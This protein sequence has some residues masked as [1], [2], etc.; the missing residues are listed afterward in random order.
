[1]TRRRPTAVLALAV[2]LVLAGCTVGYQPTADASGP[3][4]D[5][6]PLGYY[7]GY[8]HNDTLDIE[9]EDG[10]SARETEAV[11][12]RSM[13]RIQRLRGLR[14]RE[15]VDVEIVTRETFHE[16][17][18]DVWGEPTADQRRLDN[19]QHEA[20]FLVGPDEDVFDVRQRNR[21]GVVLGFYQPSEKRLVIVSGNDPATLDDE[22][23][24]AHELMH[25]LQDQHFGLSSF[26]DSTL[27]SVNARNG[28][29][30]GDATVV[31]QAY[32]R[33]CETGKWECVEARTAS[34]G[35]PVGFHWG[36]YFLGY[37]PYAEGPNFVEHHRDRGGWTTID[38][39][40]SDVPTT[41]AEIID[42]ETYRRDAYG[43][44]VVEDRNDRSWERITVR[45]GA[46][47]AT[48]GEAGLTSMFVYTAYASSSPGVVERDAFRN[49]GPNGLKSANPYT[50]DIEYASG[51]YGD[52]LHAYERGDRTAYVWNVTFVDRAN[53]TTFA[54]GYDQ[55][56]EYWG[57]E[58]RSVEDG[59]VWTFDGA[60]GPFRGAVWIERDGNAVMIVKAPSESALDDV[61]APAETD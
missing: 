11:V 51:W 42:P 25:V 44:A 1:M 14:F 21:G 26:D 20:L 33:N 13:A 32:E 18:G 5:D 27:D 52:R 12:S 9:P 47:A 15:D 61:Y 36:V 29:V 54:A 8:W 28:L 2:V 49:E 39:I 17:F 35:L 50:Y 37:F 22:V 31:E 56:A 45:N 19:V 43:E 59:T 60:D 57:G 24:L 10:L 46:E 38:Q 6:P 58:R 23:T 40:Y 30:E 55:V 48:V 3:P 16:E 53:A 34:G 41:S 4:D 7:D